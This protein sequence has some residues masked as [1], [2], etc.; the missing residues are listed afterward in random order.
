M[1][2]IVVSAIGSVCLREVYAQP[3]VGDYSN[4]GP[5]R[6]AM[7][8][9]AGRSAGQGG[10]SSSGSAIS[11]KIFLPPLPS[12]QGYADAAKEP[13]KIKGNKST[14]SQMADFGLNS[15]STDNVSLPPLRGLRQILDSDVTNKLL[16][17]LTQAKVNVLM[18]TY[19]MVENGAAT[20]FMGGMNIGSNL[21]SNMLAAQDAQF[22]MLDVLDDTGKSKEAYVRTVAKYLREGNNQ[23]IWP[24]AIYMA[25]GENGE[26]ATEPEMKRL[27]EGRQPYT[28]ASVDPSQSSATTAPGGPPPNPKLVLSDMIFKVEP[29]AGSA[30]RD[31][32][33]YQNTPQKIQEL[34][35]E[36]KKLVG[37]LE[38]EISDPSKLSRKVE[39]K[40]IAPEKDDKG[41]RGVTR[42][43][44]EEVQVVWEHLNH[45][46]AD[47]CD[48]EKNGS[49]KN[50]A[51]GEKETFC[52]STDSSVGKDQGLGSPWEL[53]SS[54][55]IP[56]TCTMV[57]QLYKFVKKNSPSTLNC[58]DDI[59]LDAQKIPED[60]TGTGSNFDDCSGDKAC[61]RKRVV[62]NLSYLIAR[63]RTLHTYATLDIITR[64]FSTDPLTQALANEQF[65]RVFNGMDIN[66]ELQNN[67]QRY[68]D[69]MDY[70]SRLNKGDVGVANSL[71][72]GQNSVPSS[73]VMGSSTGGSN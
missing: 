35:K 6:D 17:E 41:R 56:M 47:R 9:M 25:S 37:D 43:N 40:F 62:L 39:Y 70:F 66:D 29:G 5:A 72:P 24:A 34:K 67:R 45:L 7:R 1:A 49:N 59:R 64:K 10:G 54:P 27:D 33:A 3:A 2:L 68:D 28:F 19:M 50:K 38:L 63:S 60:P 36:Y 42:A 15:R 48:W 8:L 23:N 51:V 44:W 31:P 21:M 69:F 13:E 71:R 46:I 57:G 52:S 20:G 26:K 65:V 58:N 4:Q 61:L 18:Q 14:D 22:K 53:A 11:Q 32:K 12:E 16:K 55:D 30:A 73:Q